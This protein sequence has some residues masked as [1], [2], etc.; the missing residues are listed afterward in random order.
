M[1][2]VSRKVTPQASASSTTARVPS[3]STRRPKLL[4]P[5]PT[6]ETSSPLWPSAR[7]TSG[8]QL[9]LERDLTHRGQR[10]RDRAAGLGLLGVLGELGLVDPGDATLGLELRSEE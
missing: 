7:G 6:S 8:R 1:S 9:G 5:S 10:P 2:A 4:Q 3:R